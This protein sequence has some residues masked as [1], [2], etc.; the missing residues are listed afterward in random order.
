MAQAMHVPDIII[1]KE[2]PLS[3]IIVIEPLYRGFG[4]TLGNAL[5]RVLLSS[6]EGAAV[7]AFGIEGISHEFSTLDGVVEDVVQITLNL[8]RLRFKV[9]RGESQVLR[10][11]KKGKGKL[12]AADIEK[13]A[14]IEVVN[15]D[16]IIATLDSPKANV[17]MTLI[18]EKGRGYSPVEERDSSGLAVG[19]VALDARFSPV[20]RVRYKVEHTRVGQVTDLDKLTIEINTDGSISPSEALKQSGA[21][22]SSQFS[23]ISGETNQLLSSAEIRGS[24]DDEPPELNFG[25]DD[26]SFSQRTANALSNNKIN[27]VRQ[28]SELSDTEL[29]ELKGFGTKAYNEVI[30]KLKELEIR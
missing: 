20:S 23:V 18:V 21:I 1:Q 22:L 15:P 8:K 27:T 30:A 2:D 10:I 26:L 25:I 3:T 14:D 16:Q 19:M 29:K 28:L 24:E 4:I 13:S 9:Y 5:R 11:N 7:T 6:L 17:Q 12:T